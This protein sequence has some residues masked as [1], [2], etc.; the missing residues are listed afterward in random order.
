M[1][2]GDP[3][4]DELG[5]A[6]LHLH[7]RALAAEAAARAALF[8]TTGPDTAPIRLGD[9]FRL[10]EPLGRGGQGS[11]WRAVDERLDRDVAIKLARPQPAHARAHARARLR[12]IQAEARALGRMRH[13]NVVEVFDVGVW[14]DG[15]L[16]GICGADEE[17]AYFVME[18]VEGTT[19]DRWLAARPRTVAEILAVMQQVAA[20]LQAAHEL[21]LVHRDVKPTNILVGADGRARVGD[22]GLAMLGADPSLEPASTERSLDGTSTRGTGPGV[23]GTPSYMA[24]EQLAGV[25]IDARADQFALAVTLFEALFGRR[26]HK[27]HD[28]EALLLAKR[29]GAPPQPRPPRVASRAYAALARGLA[30]R[31][32]DRHPSVRAMIEA[33]A[34]PRARWSATLLVLAAATAIPAAA[35]LDATTPWSGCEGAAVGQAWDATARDELLAAIRQP[36]TGPLQMATLRVVGRLDDYAKSLRTEHGAACSAAPTKATREA[37][38]CLRWLDA[39]LDATVA[40][41]RQPDRAALHHAASLVA[42]LP[43]PSRC[44]RDPQHL[45]APRPPLPAAQ[46]EALWRALARGEALR[47]V[48]RA[49]EA[50][51]EAE[52]ARALAAPLG[53]VWTR[54]AE[55]DLA[56]ALEAAGR[57][58]PALALYEQVWARAA[59]VDD[60][61]AA[62]A[63]TGAAWVT[64]MR[65]LDHEQAQG[66]VRHARAQLERVDPPPEVTGNLS[67]IEAMLAILVGDLATAEAGVEAA[68]AASLEA[69]GEDHP[70]VHELRENLALVLAMHGRW[71]EAEAIERDVLAWREQRF[72]PDHP[73]VGK[74][75]SNLGYMLDESGQPALAEPLLRRALEVRGATLGDDHPELAKTLLTLALVE[76]ALGRPEAAVGTLERAVAIREQRLGPEDSGTQIVV[77]RLVELL[78]EA[79]RLDAARARLERLEA[80]PSALLLESRTRPHVLHA[81]ATLARHEGDAIEAARRFEAAVEAQ[82]VASMPNQRIEV[83]YRLDARDAALAVGDAVTAARH[84]QQARTLAEALPPSPDWSRRLGP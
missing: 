80:H 35:T 40:V 54:H 81:R 11:V 7:Q 37:A 5:H 44:A 8:G 18:R 75:L 46:A 30:P 12:A 58:E 39:S 57:Y 76:Q 65:L 64:G 14:S 59:V 67:A 52:R 66:W 83:D 24:P 48:G 55:L 28:R 33:L 4:G 78:A 63:A 10:C 82:A 42:S 22:F 31:P 6:A 49:D 47:Q 21:S 16:P 56:D 27:G 1:D 9:R 3:L 77:A 38:E 62:R 70:R 32:E 15:P 19:L 74:S 50:I 60:V 79:G 41:L 51:A 36:G 25:P 43:P 34:H 53:E 29:G 23:V 69:L 45:G 73:E 17:V 20:G 84:E 71:A 26:P 72:G 68:H 13:P 2:G 61:D